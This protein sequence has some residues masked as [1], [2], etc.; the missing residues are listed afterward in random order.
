MEGQL[1]LSERA[2]ALFHLLP[3]RGKCLMYLRKCDYGTA[4]YKGLN[5]VIQ[6]LDQLAEVL[7]DDRDFFELK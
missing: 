2:D 3:A 4:E 1:K 5:E 6:A 7:V